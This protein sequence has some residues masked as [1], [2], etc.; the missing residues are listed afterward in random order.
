MGGGAEVLEALGLEGAFV[1]GNLLASPL[2][3]RE[4]EMAALA[5]SLSACSSE[6]S[7][8]NIYETRRQ[9]DE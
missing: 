7:G 8:I 3:G 2:M 1:G 6:F 5:A 9:Q 4:V